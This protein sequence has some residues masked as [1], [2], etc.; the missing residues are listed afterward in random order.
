MIE[1]SG[2]SKSYGEVKAIE[3]VSFKVDKGRVVGFL[4]ANGAGKTTTMDIL[5][6]CLGADEGSAKICGIDILENPIDAKKKIGYLPDTPPLYN[7]MLVE[8]IITFS[9]KLN[10]TELTGVDKKVD[11]VILKVGLESVRKR[12]VGNLSKGYR[13]RVALANALVHEPEVLI[14]DEP[15]EGLDPNQI[16]QMRDLINSLKESHTILLSSH[17]LHEIENMCDSLVIINQGKIVATDSYENLANRF[18]SNAYSL[19]VRENEKGAM[20]KLS[21]LGWVEN[22]KLEEN[23]S[24]SFTLENENQVDE[25]A[26]FVIKEKFGL[27]ALG[28]NQSKLENIFQELTR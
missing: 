19:R 10:L 8:D 7:D 11:E 23:G 13:Q 26:G 9:A 6:G 18:S 2:L 4:G 20:E 24:I 16:A 21:D 12:L 5:C 25:V 3:K 14:L 27:R 22:P 1:V 15:T 28:P 17:I